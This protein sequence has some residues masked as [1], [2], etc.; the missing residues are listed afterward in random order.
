MKSN[1]IECASRYSVLDF[2][3]SSLAILLAGF[4]SDLRNV[5]GFCPAFISIW[6]SDLEPLA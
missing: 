3:K 6:K 4:V 1:K 5:G 2:L